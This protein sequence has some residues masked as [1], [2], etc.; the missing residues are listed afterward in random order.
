MNKESETESMKLNWERCVNFSLTDKKKRKGGWGKIPYHLIV[1]LYFRN[2]SYE[3]G[4][5][6][7]T[8]AQTFNLNEGTRPLPRFAMFCRLVINIFVLQHNEAFKKG[9]MFAFKRAMIHK[10]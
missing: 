3:R 1:Y 9:D 2:E 4:K 7:P 6:N 8:K 10:S 5:F